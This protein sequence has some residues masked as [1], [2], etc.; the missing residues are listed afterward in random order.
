MT[1]VPVYGYGLPEDLGPSA[2]AVDLCRES[3]CDVTMFTTSQQVVHLDAGGA[4]DEPGRTRS[5]KGF[6]DA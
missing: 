2:S 4:R 6:G 1:T 3:G 5:C